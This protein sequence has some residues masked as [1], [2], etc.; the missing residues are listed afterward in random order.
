MTGVGAM[1]GNGMRSVS[2]TIATR[3]L[4][5]TRVSQ[6]RFW[7]IAALW[8]CLAGAAS[9]G[10]YQFRAAPADNPLR[11]LVPYSGSASK[12]NF[13]HSLEFRYFKL[14][15]VLT[16][17]QSPGIQ[18]DWY[19]IDGFLENA[20]KRGNQGIFRLYSEYQDRQ[21]SVPDFLGVSIS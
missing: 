12:G 2:N 7:M 20:R 1:Q 19:E 16:G 6:G 11:G 3:V 15:D 14:S 4:H 21:G 17:W 10:S 13:P 9:A 5:G 18:F 8:L